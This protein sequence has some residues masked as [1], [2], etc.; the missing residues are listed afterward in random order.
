ML[1]NC[2]FIQ[3]QSETVI[4]QG[5]LKGHRF[6]SH[7]FSYI[8]GAT[9]LYFGHYSYVVI[10]LFNTDLYKSAFSTDS[11]VKLIFCLFMLSALRWIEFDI[12][13]INFVTLALHN[14]CKCQVLC[15]FF[16]HLFLKRDTGHK[17]LSTSFNK[18]KHASRE[19]LSF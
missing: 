5:L 9:K 1:L 18:R 13:F 10:I 12:T 14:Q 3:L 4:N 16:S 7:C 11:F 6:S 2:I 8:K 19:L 17:H 15:V